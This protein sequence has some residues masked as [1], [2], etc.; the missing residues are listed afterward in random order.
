[1]NEDAM[2]KAY[3]TL[4]KKMNSYML[5]YE[6]RKEPTRKTQ[7]SMEGSYSDGCLETRMGRYEMDSSDS[8]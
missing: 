5:W 7:T 4:G 1:L 3:S 2:G 6:G 8:G